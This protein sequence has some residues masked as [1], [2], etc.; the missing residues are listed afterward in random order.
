MT[1]SMLKPLLLLILAL[2]PLAAC[3]LEAGT[4]V[5]LPTCCNAELPQNLTEHY[6]R[7][8]LIYSNIV[9]DLRASLVTM[10][11]N[12][13]TAYEH[14]GPLYCLRKI[15]LHAEDQM[16]EYTY[17]Y[18]GVNRPPRKESLYYPL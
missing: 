6:R 9:D 18:F 8:A 13:R 4:A 7:Q 11:K 2:V 14:G 17:L 12:G 15:L 16:E 1:L 5:K 3:C 10:V